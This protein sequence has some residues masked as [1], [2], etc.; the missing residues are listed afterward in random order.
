M[1]DSVLGAAVMSNWNNPKESKTNHPTPTSTDKRQ[2]KTLSALHRFQK[3][4][5]REPAPELTSLRLLDPATGDTIGPTLPGTQHSA[6]G[7]VNEVDSLF[8]PEKAPHDVDQTDV[9]VTLRSDG[10]ASHVARTPLLIGSTNAPETGSSIQADLPSMKQT[11]WFHMNG[12]CTYGTSCYWSHDD[13]GKMAPPYNRT[14]LEEATCYFWAK[15][16]CSKPEKDCRW[17]HRPTLYVM[18]TKNR[19]IPFNKFFTDRGWPIPTSHVQGHGNKPE[20]QSRKISIKKTATCLHWLL[21]G[22]C[23]KLEDE[24]LGA[25]RVMNY[26]FQPGQGM[27]SIRDW[28]G[29]VTCRL[30]HYKSCPFT[31]ARDCKYQHERTRLISGCDDGPPEAHPEDIDVRSE[32]DMPAPVREPTDS[33]SPPPRSPRG[34]E[35]QSSVLSFRPHLAGAEPRS[36]V[37]ISPSMTSSYDCLVATLSLHTDNNS[38]IQLNVEMRPR[39]HEGFHNLKRLFDVTKNLDLGVEFICLSHGLKDHLNFDNNAVSGDVYHIDSDS[40]SVHN[41]FL[42][43]LRMHASV[44]VCL[45][46]CFVVVLYPPAGD[47]WQHLR[48]LSS[49]RTD[50]T[51]HFLIS[52]NPTLIA[53]LHSQSK[54]ARPMHPP[55]QLKRTSSRDEMKVMSASDLERLFAGI[56]GKAHDKN[57]FLVFHPRH[58]TSAIEITLQLLSHGAKVWHSITPGSWQSFLHQQATGAIIFMFNYL[59]LHRIP[60]L[61]YKVDT[62][63]NC[64]QLAPLDSAPLLPPT[65]PPDNAQHSNTSLTRLFPYGKVV[66]IMDDIFENHPT[67]AAR[68]VQHILKKSPRGCKL[69]YKILGR[70]KLERWIFELVS[71]KCRG[72]R[73]ISKSDRTL[74]DLR[75][76]IHEHIL[77][78]PFDESSAGS[79]P[80]P[81]SLFY[82]LPFELESDCSSDASIVANLFVRF[83]AKWSTM[84]AKD[85]RK[86]S[87]LTM[88]DERTRD[89]WEEAFMHLDFVTPSAWLS[90]EE[91]SDL[92]RKLKGE[93]RAER[94]PQAF[95][96]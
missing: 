67:E 16:R 43:T 44:A 60:K 14:P 78:D 66:L 28:N 51:F 63:C 81:A 13:R 19:K 61:M 18:D 46:Q 30:W 34:D 48:A 26:F 79:N 57:V 49:H 77:A 65:P 96:A 10:T 32:T 20:D 89:Q 84:F 59:P 90:R 31:S 42:N 15:G 70:P 80:S 3:A 22:Q 12:G 36:S 86:F 72:G 27:V 73:A 33:P 39:T 69:S 52:V 9:H 50:A 55:L 92:K 88:T 58:K 6:P 76:A 23:S 91:R 64:F 95:T 37:K 25:H 56:G 62:S 41:S 53:L 4:C 87:V 85:Y 71:R 93:H 17:L 21:R 5:R 24:C 83:F 75:T 40:V 8:I 11:C 94:P 29:P 82:W 35:M 74:L 2:I 7:C 38:L 68:V 54:V 45:T 47:E 1:A